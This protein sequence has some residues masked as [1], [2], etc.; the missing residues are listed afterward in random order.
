PRTWPK[1]LTQKWK[2]TVGQGDSSPALV[3]D[4][5]YVFARQGGDEVILCLDAGTGKEIWKE[6]YESQPARVPMGGHQGPRSTPAVGEGKVC[7]LGVTG[8]LSCLDAETG[9]VV[10]RKD[11]KAF[12]RFYT[13]S[14]PVIL[15]GKCLAYLGA[16]GKGELTA[17]DLNSGEEKWKWTGEGP[18]DG[19]PGPLPADPTHPPLTP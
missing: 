5:L 13:A 4:K 12:P 6:K 17:F 9:K 8:I 19:S 18:A 10:W 14:S 1:E 11:S 7:T 2:V 16:Q 3:G 15:D